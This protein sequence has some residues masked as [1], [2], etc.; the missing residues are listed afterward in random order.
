MNRGR[1]VRL[2]VEGPGWI[3]YAAALKAA[4]DRF[5]STRLA[6][7]KLGSAFEA[8]AARLR[9]RNNPPELRVAQ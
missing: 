9:D 4:I 8:R 3:P 6:I 2:P 5:Q 7:A 1:P